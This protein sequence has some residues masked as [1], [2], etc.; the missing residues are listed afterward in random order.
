MTVYAFYNQK[1]GVG[2]TASVVNLSYIAASEGWRTLLWDLDP[3]GA[4]GFYFQVD[5]AVKHGAKKILSNEVDLGSTV[6]PSGYDNLDIIPSDP[7]ARNSE[8]ILSE[9]KQGKKRL[10]SALASVKND[11]DIIM[12]DC[13]P[14]LSVLHDSIFQAADWILCPNIPTTLS[15]RSFN[16][17][18]EYF[19]QTN[20]SEDK[21]KAFFSMVDHRKNLHNEVLNEHYR[22]K[23]FL[24]NYIP[25]LSDIEKMGQQL[26]PVESFAKSSYA[27]QCFRDL[28]KEIKKLG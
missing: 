26:A 9:L 28:W 14:G 6:Q 27:A 17:V 3:Q 20:I 4:A 23:T 24:R 11:Y 13:P 10:K 25:Y 18:Q 1:G 2:K 16:T 7:S 19:K 12:L 8:V 5:A 22:D 21:L 15:M